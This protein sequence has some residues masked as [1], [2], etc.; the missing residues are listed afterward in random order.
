[1]SHHCWQRFSIKTMIKNQEN[2]L[3]IFCSPSKWTVDTGSRT[4]IQIKFVL[5][6]KLF[7]SITVSGEQNVDIQ[8]FLHQLQRLLVISGH[9]L[10]S[11]AQFDAKS[12]HS[13]PFLVRRAKRH[14]KRLIDEVR[15]KKNVIIRFHSKDLK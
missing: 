11:V 9:N 8:W 1:M 4:K 6:F 2:V 14:L 3:N 5:F 7:E 12:A 10:V 13:D 15:A